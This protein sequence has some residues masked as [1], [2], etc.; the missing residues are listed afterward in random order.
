MF[1]QKYFWSISLSTIPWFHGTFKDFIEIPKMFA[2][3]HP[4]LSS[5][6]KENSKSANGKFYHSRFH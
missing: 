4:F 3:L 5:F 6:I 2:L 1:L